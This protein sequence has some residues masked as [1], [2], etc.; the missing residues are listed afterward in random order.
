MTSNDVKTVVKLIFIHVFNQIFT[1]FVLHVFRSDKDKQLLH[2]EIE[3][4]SAILDAANKAKVRELLTF[5]ISWLAV[6]KIW[7]ISS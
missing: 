2:V 6:F 5:I 3:N 7:N 4:L 1:A